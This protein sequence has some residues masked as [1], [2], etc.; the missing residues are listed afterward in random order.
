L[1]AY[2]FEFR[3]EDGPGEVVS[4]LSFEPRQRIE[5]LVAGLGQLAAGRSDYRPTKRVTT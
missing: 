4:M 3:D 1:K 5:R 2:R